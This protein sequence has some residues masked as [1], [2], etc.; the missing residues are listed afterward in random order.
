MTIEEIIKNKAQLLELKKSTIKHSDCFSVTESNG[1]MKGLTTMNIDDLE[2]GIIKRSIIGNT[3][4]WL[5]S[6]GDVHVGN[7]FK[8]SISE[9]ANKVF[10]LHDHKHEVTAIVGKFESLEEKQVDW[11]E[12]GVNKT[13]QTTIL[14]GNSKIDKESNEKIYKMYLK[15]EIDQHSVGMVYTKIDLAVNDKDYKD[16]FAVWNKY[17]DQIGNKAKAEEKGYFWAVSEAKLV[18]ISAV[19][20]GSNELTNTV[21]NIEPLK[22]TQIIEPSDDTQKENKQFFINLLK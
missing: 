8:K 11:L 17:I 12:L 1:V 7:T 22:N 15:N 20:M 19:L 13:G 2:N 14:L 4:N 5:D 3:Y 6:H 21:Q 16:E 10:H 18:E 9:R